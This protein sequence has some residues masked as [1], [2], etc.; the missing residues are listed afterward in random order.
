MNIAYCSSTTNILEKQNKNYH[1]I[2]LTLCIYLDFMFIIV[3]L[4]TMY[5]K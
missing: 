3:G 2:K 1:L 5:I 4:L